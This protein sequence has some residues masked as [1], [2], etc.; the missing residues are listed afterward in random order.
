G[1]YVP[2]ACLVVGSMSSSVGGRSEARWWPPTPTNCSEP[3]T[4]IPS[5]AP[6]LNRALRGGGRGPGRRDWLV[7]G[8]EWLGGL[9]QGLA[10]GLDAE[11]YLDQ[12]ADEHDGGAD[13]V[14]PEQG[15]AGGAGADQRAVEG[16]ADRAGDAADGE[17]H[18]DRLG[19]D[20]DRPGFGD[21]QVGGAGAGRG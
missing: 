6:W 17:E 16:R 19:A 9:F 15:G 13:D 10:G 21:G 4:G 14:S 8:G 2:P 11:E 1:S 12:A 7:G 18:R 5:A 20:L 3:P